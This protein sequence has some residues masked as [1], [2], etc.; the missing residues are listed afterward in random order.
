MSKR[1]KTIAGWVAF[2]FVC[3]HITA[4]FVYASPFQFGFD[5]GK[6]L[7]TP[8]VSPLFEQTWSMFAP[9]PVVT[10]KIYVKIEYHDETIDWFDPRKNDRKWHK[11]LRGS[12]H[13]D[14]VLLEANVLHYIWDQAEEL[15]LAYDE[16]IPENLIDVYKESGGYVFAKRYGYGVARNQRNKEPEKIWIKADMMNLQTRESG[17]LELPVMTWW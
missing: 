13:G 6:K 5:K 9:C 4:L 10:G 15:Q 11:I 2:L 3:F 7:V 12:H 14:R 17:V 16:P 1:N 8:Y